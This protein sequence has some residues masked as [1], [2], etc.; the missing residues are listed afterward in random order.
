V[1]SRVKSDGLIRD[2]E[3]AIELLELTAQSGEPARHGR[4]IA[5]V[6]IRTKETIEGG[7]DERRF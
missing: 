2:P 1:E 3:I 6:V 4:G 5:D 7:F